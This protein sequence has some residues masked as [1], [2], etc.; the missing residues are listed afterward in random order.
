MPQVTPVLD[1]AEP[2][3]ENLN[4]AMPRVGPTLDQ[5]V[6]LGENM[7]AALAQIGYLLNRTNSLLERA[8][9]VVESVESKYTEGMVG[10]TEAV[11][12]KARSAS[13]DL[14]E[15]GPSFLREH[16]VAREEQTHDETS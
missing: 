7:N 3:V 12:A 6:S 9:A 13:H 11:A 10:R 14:R 15:K 5:M 2:L 8:D 16:G 1:Q 4:A